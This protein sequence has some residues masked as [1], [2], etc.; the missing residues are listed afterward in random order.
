[1]IEWMIISV[2]SVIILI[3]IGWV[4]AMCVNYPHLKEGACGV[5]CK[6]N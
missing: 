6:G 2:I 1:M 3:V 4:I 5:T